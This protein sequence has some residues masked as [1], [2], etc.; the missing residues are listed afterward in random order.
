MKA[1]ENVT[2][3]LDKMKFFYGKIYENSLN[4]IVE[5]SLAKNEKILFAKIVKIN[6]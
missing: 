1:T 6:A 2:I 5:L 4:S 3:F